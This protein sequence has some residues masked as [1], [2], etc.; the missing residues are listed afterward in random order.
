MGASLTKR[1]TGCYEFLAKFQCPHKEA[2]EPSGIR[3]VRV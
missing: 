2:D 1:A 3:P